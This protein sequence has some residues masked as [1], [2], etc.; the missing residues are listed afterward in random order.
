MRLVNE[1]TENVLATNVELATT[2]KARRVGLLGRTRLDPA[3]G[4]LLAPCCMVHTAFMRFPIDVLFV[5]RD[6]RALRVLHAVKPWRAV[7]SMRAHAAI[8]LAAGVLA[9]HRVVA[10]DRIVLC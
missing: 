6:G 8:E 7:A 3:A 4:L 10:G 1:R 9:Q 2:R 5:A